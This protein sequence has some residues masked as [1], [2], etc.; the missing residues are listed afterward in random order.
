MNRDP[1]TGRLLWWR[2]LLPCF[3]LDVRTWFRT[4]S[5]GPAAAV[6]WTAFFLIFLTTLYAGNLLLIHYP[7]IAP[8][9]IFAASPALPI[10]TSDNAD[11]LKIWYTAQY[12][13]VVIVN[14]FTASYILRPSQLAYRVAAS[15]AAEKTLPNGWQRIEQLNTN[16][17]DVFIGCTLAAFKACQDELQSIGGLDIIAL[18]EIKHGH[19][20]ITCRIA[21]TLKQNRP[22]H[23]QGN[24]L[25]FD[26]PRTVYWYAARTGIYDEN[27]VEI[28]KLGHS[29]DP[30]AIRMPAY[31]SGNPAAEFYRRTDGNE[32]IF[33][34]TEDTSENSL[35]KRFSH[36]KY[37]NGNG[38]REFYRCTDEL[39]N[40]LESYVSN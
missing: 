16:T 13:L 21:Q 40:F 32:A 6:S 17:V 35:K 27:G 39:R 26:D 15:I 1:L 29:Y 20:R 8:G 23:T 34:E 36:L 31:I 10:L 38:G 30:R 12:F 18:D 14:N 28:I 25:I 3:I 33:P 11:H 22:Y 5:G 19:I 37:S 4:Y 7:W 24:R 2:L 9:L